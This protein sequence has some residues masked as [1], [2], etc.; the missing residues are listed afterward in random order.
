MGLVVVEEHENW[1]LLK[2]YSH[3]TLYVSALITSQ[4]AT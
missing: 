4:T 2:A 3:G 1:F